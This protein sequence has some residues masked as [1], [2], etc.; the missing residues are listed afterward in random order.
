MSDRKPSYTLH[1]K[2]KERGAKSVRI[3]TCWANDYGGFNVSPEKKPYKDRPV[4][5]RI[6]V[7][8]VGG[9]TMSTDDAYFDLKPPYDPERKK[10]QERDKSDERLAEQFGD[11][12]GPGDSDLPF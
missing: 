7:E 4:V 9:A 2:P 8:F 12:P 3:A 11:D 6:V 1:A 10:R 5:A